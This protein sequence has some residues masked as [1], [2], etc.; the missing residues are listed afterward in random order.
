MARSL[1]FI[2]SG[3]I[4]PVSGADISMAER[5]TA[6]SNSF[7]WHTHAVAYDA[8]ANRA[9][10]LRLLD[11]LEIPFEAADHVVSY[12][13]RGLQVRLRFI[14]GFILH[15][16]ASRSLVAEAFLED[17][18]T[19]S[20]RT[21]LANFRDFTA[22]H[23]AHSVGFPPVCYLTESGVPAPAELPN[24]KLGSQV[25]GELQSVREVIVASRFLA[26]RFES[27]W[28][29]RALVLTN[30]IELAPFTQLRQTDGSEIGAL[31]PYTAKGLDILLHISRSMPTRQFIVPAGAGDDFRLR[32]AEIEA[33]PN[34]QLLPFQRSVSDFYR[35]C[36][37]VLVPSLVEEGFSRVVIEA[38]ASGRPVIASD[39]GGTH[40]AGGDGCD[41]VS[42]SDVRAGLKPPP[43]MLA[44]WREQI[45]RLDDPETY[46]LAVKRANARV[47]QYTAELQRDL[48]KLNDVLNDA[49]R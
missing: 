6:L 13:V 33:V 49:A 31:H 37:L 47:E 4:L 28:N 36:R 17:L 46:A 39:I 8:P 7:G 43:S 29:R 41:Y 24:D 23:A 12:T 34:L 21:L 1:L 45:E 11:I 2:K 38:L 19:L 44:E 9:G 32:K 5:L 20:P 30:V 14:P 40:E 18:S 15:S 42:T 27:L 3:P 10:L 35:R 25:R 22:V 48:R 16:A 26:S